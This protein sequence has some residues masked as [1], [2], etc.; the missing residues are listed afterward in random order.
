MDFNSKLQQNKICSINKNRRYPDNYSFRFNDE[1]TEVIEAHKYLGTGF[2][3]NVG[4]RSE[5]L[6][7][8]E[9]AKRVM[10]SI[11]GSCRKFDCPAEL[12]LEMYN[13]KVLSV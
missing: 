6:Q 11:I 5:Y 13:S 3:C 7:Y 10:H 1:S 12:Q 4:L 2:N 9:Q 8:T